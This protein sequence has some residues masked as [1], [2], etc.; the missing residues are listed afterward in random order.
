MKYKSFTMA[1][2][3]ITL[4]IIGIVAAITLPALIGNYKKKEN[5]AL[6]KKAYTEISQAL[7]RAEAD[8]GTL[9]SWNFA[10]FMTSSERN[11]YFT[12]YYLKPYMELIYIC[13]T[14]NGISETKKCW[15]EKT[16]KLNGQE[17]TSMLTSGRYIF[18]TPAG[19][20]VLYWLHGTG[21]GG[22]FIVDV[23]GPKK[24]P[25]QMGKDIFRFILTFR[26]AETNYNDTKGYEPGLRGYG[27][28]DEATRENLLE[29]C[30]KSGTGYTCAGLIMYDGWEVKKDYPW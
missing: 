18:V 3:L 7:S 27:L 1:E 14:D 29:K 25:N 28:N 17:D 11:D 13:S 9:D 5:I 8:Y 15:T 19:Y 4:G 21:T 16:L 10:N 20:S 24:A 12:N 6:L 30:S 2:V 26:D 23:N 22:H